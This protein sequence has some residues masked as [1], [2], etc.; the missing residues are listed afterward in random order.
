MQIG[1]W[2]LNPYLSFAIGAFVELL[3]YIFVHLILDRIG[4]KKPYFIFAILFGVVSFLI[5]PTQ[6]FTTK[7]SLSRSMNTYKI[8]KVIYFYIHFSSKDNIKFDSYYIEISCISILCYHLYL[9]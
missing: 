4:R 9:C 1:S 7:N 5:I 6:K 3:A 2:K 8:F